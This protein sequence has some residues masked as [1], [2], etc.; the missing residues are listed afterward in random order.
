MIGD[1]DRS[2]FEGAI[3]RKDTTTVREG[4]EPVDKFLMMHRRISYADRNFLSLAIQS[5][6]LYALQMKMRYHHRYL[7]VLFVR[8]DANAYPLLSIHVFPY[9]APLKVLENIIRLILSA[10]EIA[11]LPRRK[12]RRSP[13]MP[14]HIFCARFL[15]PS[16]FPV[17]LLPWPR[18]NSSL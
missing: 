5:N 18:I 9:T 1:R 14:S 17:S 3:K 16:T 7:Y 8:V 10:R 6:T 15:F 13:C 4:S 12:D 2:L 11:S